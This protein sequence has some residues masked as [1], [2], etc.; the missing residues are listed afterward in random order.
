MEALKFH[1]IQ[2]TEQENRDQRDQIERIGQDDSRRCVLH[3]PVL[4]E[5]SL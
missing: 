5:S 4:K 2:R 1:V 3:L